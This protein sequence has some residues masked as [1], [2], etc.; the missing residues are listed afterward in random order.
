[1]RDLSSYLRLVE[2]KLPGHLVRVPDSVSHEYDVTKYVEEAAR[3][4]LN[5]ALF[6]E[7]VQSFQAPLLINVFGHVD[8]IKLSLEGATMSVDSRSDLYG[9]WSSLMGKVIE[10]VE[11]ESGPVKEVVHLGGAV[12]ITKLPILRFYEQDAGRYITSGLIAARDQDKPEVINLSYA[13][14]QVKGP[15]KI[16]TT[17]HSRGNLWSYFER[18]KQLGKPLDVAV[19]IGAHPALY[20][21][22]AAKITGEYGTAGSLI[23]EPVRLVKAETVD[24]P[25]PA[26]AEIILEGKITLDEEDEGPF[27]EYSGYLSGRSTR[28]VLMVDCITMRKDA[29]YQTI[30]PSNSDEHLLLSGLP[31]QARIYGA[32]KGFT[33]MPTVRDIVWPVS[34]THYVCFI[35]MLPG[36]KAVPGLAKQLGILV[37]GLDPYLKLVVILPEN[38]DIDDLGRVLCTIAERCNASVG[39]GIELLRDVF[40]HRLDPSSSPEGTSSKM[41]IDA[42]GVSRETENVELKIGDHLRDLGVIDVAYPTIDYALRVLKMAQ[43]ADTKTALREIVK[44]RGLTICV[45]D[46]IDITDIRQVIWGL[47]TRFQPAEDLVLFGGGVGIDGTKPPDWKAKKATIPY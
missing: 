37:M 1:M 30:M 29:I 18:S 4:R 25:V 28:N 20:L 43:G 22:A 36:A 38:T 42:T 39:S 41:I 2:S 24:V 34:G 9:E 17:L 15:R 13:R 7:H 35:S 26:D 12:D 8:R 16:G 45:D 5:P 47:S 23:G 19:I 44:S 27:T 21:A 3:N 46:D 10:P 32:V 6:F 33:P 11:A 31:K 40:C 14:M